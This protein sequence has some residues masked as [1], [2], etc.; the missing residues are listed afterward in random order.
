MSVIDEQ[1]LSKVYDDLQNEKTKL[2]LD[3]KN[4]KELV[5]ERELNQKLFCIDSILK[6]VIKYRNLKIK[7]KLKFEL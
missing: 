7:D 6:G 2:F 4:D 1:Y 5:R 3:L